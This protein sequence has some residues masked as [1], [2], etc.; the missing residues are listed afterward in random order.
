MM[1]VNSSSSA[2]PDRIWAVLGDVDNWGESLPTF[3]SVRYID[4]PS[5]TAVGSRFEVRQPGLAKA[6][7]E[8]TEWS[9][10]R[11]FTWV[12]RAPGVTT[13]AIHRIE[14]TDIGSG[15]HLGIEWSGP[16]AGVIRLLLTSKAQRM[17][18][19]EADTIVRL[20]EQS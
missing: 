13:T 16:L 11:K 9:P 1:E 5:P 6:T 18:Q 15:L 19:S 14:T 12:G 7:Y 3:D 20:A 2:T 10:G 4:G 17:M 8:V